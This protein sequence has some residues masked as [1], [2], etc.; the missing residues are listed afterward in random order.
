MHDSFLVP[1]Q[2]F[3][4]LEVT[5]SLYLF[6]S[7]SFL[8]WNDSITQRTQQNRWSPTDLHQQGQPQPTGDTSLARSR[9]PV[10]QVYEPPSY[11]SWD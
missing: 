8:N 5:V 1:Q 6:K 2:F 11:R 3:S 10:Q 9:L 4:F 7:S